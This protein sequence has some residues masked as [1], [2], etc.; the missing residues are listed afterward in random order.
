[1]VNYY[2]EEIHKNERRKQMKKLL[3]IIIAAICFISLFA[4]SSSAAYETKPGV[5]SK[6]TTSVTTNS[7]TVRWNA[8]PGAT[9]YRIYD[10]D[11]SQGKWMIA[12]NKTAKTGVSISNLDP[13]MKYY[14]AIKAY[15]VSGDKTIWASKYTKVTI[16]TR[17][18]Y[19]YDVYSESSDYSVSLS[20]SKATGATGYRVYQYMPSTKSWKALKTTSARSYNVTGLT[21]AKKYIFAVKPYTKKSGV[22]SWA[23]SYTKI[24]T[25]TSPKAP[26]TID[27]STTSSSVTLSWP[28][29]TGATGY[30]VQK[31]N[32]STGK[33]ST[34]QDTTSRS[35]TISSLSANTSYKFAVSSYIK[36]GTN[37]I[38]SERMLTIT[39]KTKSSSSSSA[40]GTQDPYNVHTYGTYTATTSLTV[41]KS[42]SSSSA[43]ICSIA[44]GT[45]VIAMSEYSS[46]DNGYAYVYIPD[47]EVYGWVLASYLAPAPSVKPGFS[48]KNFT[49]GM[50]ARVKFNTP[51]HAGI[52][53]RSGPSSSYSKLCTLPEGAIIEIAGSY[54]SGNNGYIKV[55]YDHPHAG[56][57]MTGWVLASYLEYYDF[58]Y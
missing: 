13:G 11:F 6:V 2:Y 44:K 42:A 3:T 15:T 29:V 34:F 51:S 4:L 7:A 36:S 35:V 21:G 14:I 18:D 48:Y 8:V 19:V 56:E 38:H 20:W 43:K 52:N 32:S 37:I 24:N 16:V 55:T 30:I 26:S 33:W 17:P 1:M 50:L 9:G 23:S 40:T 25:A 45:E 54:Y 22:T 28:K 46:L 5:T 53:M 10:W 39:V 49:I 41:R 12:V 58:T 47:Y 31:Y 57:V 27:Y